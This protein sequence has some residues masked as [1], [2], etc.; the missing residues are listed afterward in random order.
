MLKLVIIA[1]CGMQK[2]D[3]Y[4]YNKNH[5]LSFK[6]HV[7]FSGEILFWLFHK[8]GQMYFLMLDG[9]IGKQLK[10]FKL[11]QKGSGKVLFTIT[12]KHDFSFLK[13]SQGNFYLQLELLILSSTHILSVR[14]SVTLIIFLYTQQTSFMIDQIKVNCYFYQ[15]SFKQCCSFKNNHIFTD[16]SRNSK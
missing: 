14:I 16:T 6:I 8:K 3:S 12:L 7:I 10:S 1:L 2:D 15:H 13:L 9:N 5:V 4:N 11:I